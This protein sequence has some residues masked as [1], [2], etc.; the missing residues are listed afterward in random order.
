MRRAGNIGLAWRFGNHTLA[1]TFAYSKENDY[2]SYGLSLNDAI[3]FNEKNTIFNYGISHNFDSV[4]HNDGAT[5]SSKDSTE[6]L[7]G[8]S[9]LLSPKDI[10]NIAL[11]YG[12]DSGYLNDPYRA[13]EYHPSFF[14]PNV[15]TAVPE[16]RPANRN[17]EIL[18]GSLTH[19]FDSLN[20]SLEGSYRFHHDS[21]DV[22]SHTVAA[23]WHQ[24]LG[25]HLLVEP[26]FRFSQQSA[27]SFY[28]TQFS[29]PFTSNPAGFHSSDYRLSEF[30][31]L[32]F[33]LQI[34]AIVNEHFRVNAGYHRYEMYGL[35]NTS[36]DMYPQANI[37]T[38]GVQFLW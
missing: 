16:R 20:A 24:R 13:A 1:P 27:A 21:Y 3:E 36:A 9:Q 33:G 12:N 5:W 15:T 35:D 2:L 25:E 26:L 10:L 23:T 37:F 6:V 18:F 19:H 14:P 31:S 38:V 7:I 28:T 4:R 30:Y 29:G 11:T 8:I 34:T 22:F 32:D 17:K